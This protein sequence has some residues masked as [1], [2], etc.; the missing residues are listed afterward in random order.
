MEL[1]DERGDDAEDTTDQNPTHVVFGQN[2]ENGTRVE[3]GQEG[4]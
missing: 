4:S 1:I 2:R 3:A